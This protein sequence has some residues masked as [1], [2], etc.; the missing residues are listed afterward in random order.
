MTVVS[1]PIYHTPAIAGL[2]NSKRDV[3]ARRSGRSHATSMKKR[4][5]MPD[6]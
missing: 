2:V 5:I 4:A 1:G 6:R 3:R